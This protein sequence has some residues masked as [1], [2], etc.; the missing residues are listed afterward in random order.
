MTKLKKIRYQITFTVI[1]KFSSI[2]YNLR[3]KHLLKL[4]ERLDQLASKFWDESESETFF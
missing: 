4:N 2:V 1:D 3:E